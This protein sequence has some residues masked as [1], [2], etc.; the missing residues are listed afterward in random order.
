MKGVENE[1][2]S[3]G[4]YHAAFQTGAHVGMSKFQGS[5]AGVHFA[6]EVGDMLLH[7]EMRINVDP[8]NSDGCSGVGWCRRGDCYIV[9]VRELKAEG[10]QGIAIVR[11]PFEMGSN[12]SGFCLFAND[13]AI[14]G[15]PR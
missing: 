14:L 6:I 5:D 1:R 3:D 15:A 8:K 9:F 7:M 4:T 10:V 11:G 12:P 13:D 2:L